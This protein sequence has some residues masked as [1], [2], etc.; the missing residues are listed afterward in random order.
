[1]PFFIGQMKE[2]KALL[3]LALFLALNN[4]SL[5]AQSIST[6]L[7]EDLRLTILARQPGPIHLNV[8]EGERVLA[9]QKLFDI[10]SKNLAIKLK[11]AVL[12]HKKSV[13]RQKRLTAPKTE[14]E[15]KLAK[16]RF[17][18]KKRLFEAG[19]ISRDAFEI[20]MLEHE[21]EKQPSRLED[22]AIA[23]FETE[24][25]QLEVELAKV[26][27]ENGFYSAPANGQV[28]RLYVRD[29]QWL[30]SG[31]KVMDFLSVNPLFVALDIPIKKLMMF[32][33]QMK[34]NL[35]IET[36]NETTEFE[37]TIVYIIDE[38]DAVDQVGRILIQINNE[39][40]LFKPGMRV[41]VDLP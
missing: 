23:S 15:V 22:L 4:V 7:L 41:R 26:R 27:F 20:D 28:I 3:V 35:K 24:E 40:Q 32:S 36:G 1:M 16:A 34:L 29:Q 19:G 21:L 38:L 39:K 2:I 33:P 8:A 10:D 30:T 17:E 5:F 9:N 25:R 31:Q 37:G 12:Q 11:L 13:S 14:N 18:Q 6:V